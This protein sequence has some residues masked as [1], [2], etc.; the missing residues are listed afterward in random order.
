MNNY[1]REL[2]TR[3]DQKFKPIM[4][5]VWSGFL[6][7]AIWIV[8]IIATIMGFISGEV[9]ASLGMLSLLLPGIMGIRLAQSMIKISL[10]EEEEKRMAEL[11]MLEKRKNHA[12]E[13]IGLSDEGELIE[14]DEYFEEEAQS[15]YS[16]S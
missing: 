1:E 9:L 12:S 15:R 7:L 3:V 13:R 5:V 10:T 16:A 2:E 11:G 6:S 14:Y 4:H 8:L